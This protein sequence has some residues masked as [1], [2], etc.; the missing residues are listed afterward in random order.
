MP[1]SKQGLANVF[2]AI[3][4]VLGISISQCVRV[5]PAIRRGL[6]G[7]QYMAAWH[8]KAQSCGG[9]K[10]SD[11]ERWMLFSSM[12]VKLHWTSWPLRR[13]VHGLFE[14]TLIGARKTLRQARDGLAHKVAVPTASWKGIAKSPARHA[15]TSQ[16]LLANVGTFILMKHCA[17]TAGT[18]FTCGHSLAMSPSLNWSCLTSWP[19]MPTCF[20]VKACLLACPRRFFGSGLELLH[21][22][23]RHPVFRMHM[24]ARCE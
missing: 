2:E 12:F 10:F 13:G 9:F 14:Q 1:P 8:L 17:R 22:F 20:F 19:V 11:A 16:L 3:A 7:A 18:L 4:T 5:S 23:P 24:T 21:S 15:F 6:L